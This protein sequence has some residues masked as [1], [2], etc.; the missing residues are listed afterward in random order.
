MPWR[1]KAPPHFVGTSDETVVD[2]EELGGVV[3]GAVRVARSFHTGVQ[4][5]GLHC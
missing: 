1:S 5:C 2:E 4:E 3:D